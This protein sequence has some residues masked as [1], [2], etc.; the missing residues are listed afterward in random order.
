MSSIAPFLRLL[1]VSL[2]SRGSSVYLQNRFCQAHWCIM[3]WHQWAYFHFNTLK[4]FLILCDFFHRSLWQ[5]ESSMEMIKQSFVSGHVS[6]VYLS[7]PLQR[8]WGNDREP[9]LEGLSP[10]QRQITRFACSSPCTRETCHNPTRLSRYPTAASGSN[11]ALRPMS[12]HLLSLPCL[13]V[14][15]QITRN[16]PKKIGV[17]LLCNVERAMAFIQCY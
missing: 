15:R 10:K 14:L 1:A 12:C 11:N 4:S 13:V 5:N 6:S 9:W 7:E 3:H 8:G 17:V 2:S 16:I